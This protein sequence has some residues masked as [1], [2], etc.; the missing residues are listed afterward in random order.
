[1]DGS[2]GRLLVVMVMF[3]C[4][5]LATVAIKSRIRVMVKCSRMTVRINIYS[6]VILFIFMTF[7]AFIKLTAYL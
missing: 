2:L 6:K 4:C 5:A 7:N 3:G 1:M